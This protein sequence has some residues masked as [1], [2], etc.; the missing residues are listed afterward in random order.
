MRFIYI[1]T[2]N[3]HIRLENE[4]KWNKLKWYDDVDDDLVIDD[5]ILLIKHKLIFII[6]GEI[7]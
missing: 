2:Y 7:Y 5:S 6:T 1:Y 3:A 4:F